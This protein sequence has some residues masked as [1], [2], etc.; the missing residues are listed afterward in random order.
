MG[1]TTLFTLRLKCVEDSL[2]MGFFNKMLQNAADRVAYGFGSQAAAGR[3]D[4]NA[5]TVEVKKQW[6]RYAGRNGISQPTTR[7]LAN[8]LNYA[9]G[10]QVEAED[11]AELVGHTGSQNAVD[12]DIAAPRMANVL[13]ENGLVVI[14]RP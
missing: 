2:A 11:I 7:H 9:W 14:Q 12:M 1:A 13:L 5:V 10:A 6:A 4:L 8:F 3:L